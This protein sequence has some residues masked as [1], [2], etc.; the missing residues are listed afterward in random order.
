[1]YKG[2]K[3]KKKEHCFEEEKDALA[4]TGNN[5]CDLRTETEFHF[6][7][8]VRPAEVEDWAPAHTGSGRKGQNREA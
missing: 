2:E 1:M 3:K 6:K 8:E 7:V 4:A 5:K